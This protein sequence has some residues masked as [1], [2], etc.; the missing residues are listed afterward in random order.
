MLH[1]IAFVAIAIC[2]IFAVIGAI[3]TSNP[4]PFRPYVLVDCIIG[5]GLVILLSLHII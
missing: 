3:P 5:V 4:N 2:F 1:I